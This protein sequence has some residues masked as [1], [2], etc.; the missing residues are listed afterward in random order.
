MPTGAVVPAVTVTATNNDTG[1]QRAAKTG[2]DGAY[3]LSLLPPGNYK[4]L[5]S[6]T[7]FKTSEVGAV[8]VNVTE[9][10]VLDKVLEVG[11]QAEQVRWKRMSKR[12]KRRVPL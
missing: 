4:V 2:A 12:S 6:A 9:T 7:G 11:S 3:T 8:Q 1:Q 5:F 10:P